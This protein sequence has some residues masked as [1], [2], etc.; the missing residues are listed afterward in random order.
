MNI[1]E[2]SSLD[3]ASLVKTN[4]SN[5]SL[6][7]QGQLASKLSE[8]FTSDEEKWYIANLYAYLKFHPVNDYVIDLENVFEMIG[9]SKKSNAKRILKKHFVDNEDYKITVLPTEQGKFSTEKIT[10]NI[11][12]FKELCVTANIDKAKQI[13]DYYI[14]LENILKETRIF[15]TNIL[16]KRIASLEIL[17][18]SQDTEIRY[19][20]IEKDIQQLK[21][22]NMNYRFC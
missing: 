7:F 13:Y 11:K 16:K 8:N 14:E 5:I 4:P 12:T 20:E 1:Q 21:L 22:G 15:Y 2:T 3:F 17:I 19:L 10:L 6:R 9:F 18:S